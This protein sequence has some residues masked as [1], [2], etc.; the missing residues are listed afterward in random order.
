MSANPAAIDLQPNARTVYDVFAA[1]AAR[2]PDSALIAVPQRLAEAWELPKAEFTYGEV[3]TEVERLRALYAGA[4]YG[5]GH[6]VALLLENRP[7]LY[8]HWLALN[9]LGVSL[10][11]INPDYRSEETRYLLD[12][13][14]AVL[15]VA[16]AHRLDE[17]RAIAA[18]S[19]RTPPVIDVARFASDLPR[20][21]RPGSGR[22]PGPADEAALLYTSGT[23]GRP[24][25]CMLSNAYFHG[26]GRRYVQIGGLV[27][28]RPGRERLLQPLPTF[29]VNA[30][31]NAFQGMLFSGGCQ[32]VL[33]RFHPKLWWREAAE[34]RAT[35]FHYLGVMPAM[36][37]GVAPSPD[38]RRHGLRLGFG[39]GVE[40]AHHAAFEARFGCVLTDGWAMTEAGGTGLM[41][42]CDEP[43]VI[44]E[45][46]MGLPPPDMEIRLV[47][48][49]A[50]DI[51]GAG[52]GEMLVRAKGADPR[53]GFF[54][55]YFKDAAATEAAWAGGWFHTGDVIRRDEAGRLYFGER[56]KSII[57]RSGENIAP[58]E[59][60]LVLYQCPLVRNVAV[61]A[62]AD[63]VRGEEVM[64]CIE[65]A[66]GAKPDRATADALFDW[67]FERLAYYKA[68]GYVAFFDGLPTTS[69]QKVQKAG[70]AAL[71]RDPS[72]GKTVFDLRERKRRERQT[73]APAEGS[74]R[75]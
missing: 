57:R 49:D 68:P 13:S 11:P 29:H 14:E 34:T 31:G 62:A 36:L 28:L 21:P 61:I 69:T 35:I 32:I 72:S 52:Q 42:A 41:S 7:L 64:A 43:R 45:R 19:E 75:L 22:A 6:R 38:D 54:S 12:H 66:E 53:R 47:D 10:V 15:V 24:K 26:W 23:T 51:A 18:T 63:P 37:L 46:C 30:I 20:A 27:S 44:G 3:T 33:D 1:T 67:C 9:G 65:P 2:Q 16:L 60:E 5:H 48:G 58:A 39:G 70:L 50:R 59:I 74:R 55:G 56:K 40:P 25:G 73:S 4:G 17:L 71:G 8:V